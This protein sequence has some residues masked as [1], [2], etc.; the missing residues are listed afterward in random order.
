MN[1]NLN[2]ENNDTKELLAKLDFEFFLKQNILV[3]RYGEKDIQSIYTS[4]KTNLK[5]LKNRA[6]GNKKQF[7]YFTEGKV[8]KMF[9]GGLLPAMFELSDDRSHTFID[10]PGIGENWAYFKH[11]QKYYRR[12]ITREKI[13]SI[14]LKSGSILA[15]FLSIIKV[16]E[17]L[18]IAS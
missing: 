7:H 4:Y 8:R 11:W 10:F 16:L 2:F 12:K 3:E 18:K 1:T 6:I 17:Y 5:E 15:I 9:I 14:V 13:W